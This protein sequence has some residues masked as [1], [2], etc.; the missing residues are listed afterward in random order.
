MVSNRTKSKIGFT[1]M[2]I[3]L[4]ALIVLFGTYFLM[5]SRAANVDKDP[6]GT[7][8]AAQDGSSPADDG[9]IDWNYWQSVNPDVIGWIE[10]PGTKIDSPIVQAHADD[11]T[12]YLHHDVYGDRNVYGCPYL[13]AG[14]E[15]T[16]GLAS[17]NAVIF[18]HHMNDGSMFAAFAKFSDEDFLKAHRTIYIYTPGATY[19][20]NAQASDVVPGWDAVKRTAFTSEADFDAYAKERLDDCGTNLADE[21]EVATLTHMFTFVTCSYNRWQNERTLVYAW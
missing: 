21:K 18:G 13:D 6:N 16:G 11:P 7:A 4:I 19:V 5:G 2:G 1:V 14:C 15:D 10:V 8:E 3:S 20:V 17:P 9:G 12:F